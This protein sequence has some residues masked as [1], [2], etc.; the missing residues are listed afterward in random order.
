M[1]DILTGAVGWTPMRLESSSLAL[2]IG[3]DVDVGTALSLQ[4]ALNVHQRGPNVPIVQHLVAEASRE[5]YWRSTLENI[6][7]MQF[8]SLRNPSAV[9]AALGGIA[10]RVG[11]VQRLQRDIKLLRARHAQVQVIPSERDAEVAV[12]F[13]SL[14]FHRRFWLRCSIDSGYPMGSIAWKVEVS[15]GGS[16]LATAVR[17]MIASTLQGLLSSSTHR[18]SWLPLLCAAVERWT[19]QEF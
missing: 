18:Y 10:L 17:D 5:A 14:K 15:L 6:A 7:V 8:S 9:V 19:T 2:R 1:F 4:V 13:S 12:L 11:R 16:S 3:G